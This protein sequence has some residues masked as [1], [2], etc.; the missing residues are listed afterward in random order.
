MG[1]I[2]DEDTL[3]NF[4]SIE[5]T[6]QRVIDE[7]A[8]DDARRLGLKQST[9]KKSRLPDGWEPVPAEARRPLKAGYPCCYHCGSTNFGID[10][11][12]KDCGKPPHLRRVG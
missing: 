11:P 12:C 8:E 4:A 2:F 3:H 9:A 1:M 7:M 6:N 10:G 5:H